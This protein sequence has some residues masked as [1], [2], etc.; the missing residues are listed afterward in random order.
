MSGL[1]AVNKKK[2]RQNVKNMVPKGCINFWG[3]E[4]KNGHFVRLIKNKFA[5]KYSTIRILSHKFPDF[6]IIKFQW[7]EIITFLM[8]L[9][10]EVPSIPLF[11][12]LQEIGGK[13]VMLLAVSMY[14]SASARSRTLS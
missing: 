5:L 10:S 14:S 8:K 2:L 9:I 11:I 7:N 13:A 12:R 1:G 4:P 6:K 3:Q